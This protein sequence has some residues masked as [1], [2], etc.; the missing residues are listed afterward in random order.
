MVYPHQGIP[1]IPGYLGPGLNAQEPSSPTLMETMRVD[2]LGI[3][4]AEQS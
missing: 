1:Y 3:D 4:Q 2:F